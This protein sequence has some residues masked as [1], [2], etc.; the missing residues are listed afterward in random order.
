[1]RIAIQNTIKPQSNGRAMDLTLG[2]QLPYQLRIPIM[3]YIK[4]IV[5][6]IV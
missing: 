5:N 2:N 3:P 4:S 1:M 6:K